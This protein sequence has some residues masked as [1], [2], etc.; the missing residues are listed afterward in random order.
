VVQ[1]HERYNGE[2]YPDRLSGSRIHP[3][4][5]I[6]G[7]ADFYDA[8]T[9]DRVYRPAMAS[10]EVYEFIMGSGNFY[11]D[12]NVVLAF[13]RNITAYPIGTMVHLNDGSIGVVTGCQRGFSH[14]PAVQ[15]TMDSRGKSLPEP[16]EISLLDEVRISIVEVLQE[17]PSLRA[18]SLI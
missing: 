14:R 9:A 7:L 11:F 12:Y 18:S 6:A 15:V 5:R 17:L 16:F 2:G 1:H 3:Y 13:L 4:A 8:M 10:H